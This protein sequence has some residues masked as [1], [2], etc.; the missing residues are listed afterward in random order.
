MIQVRKLWATPFFTGTITRETN[1]AARD[2]ILAMQATA[3]NNIVNNWTTPD[4]LHTRVEFE[5]LC[6]EIR[7]F[8]NES[9][10]W[11]TVA[12]DDIII[13]CMWANVAPLGCVHLEHVH[14]NAQYSGVVYLT[15]PQGAAGTFFRDPRAAAT[16]FSPDY[17]NPSHEIIGSDFIIMPEAGKICMWP[18]WL[19]HGVGHNQPD[20]TVKRIVVSYN[21]MLRG[22]ST[23]P[24]AYLDTRNL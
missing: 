16:M 6:A 23:K 3:D 19:A 20:I 13:N 11:L 7:T 21:I 22:L 9:L 4:D 12:R 18:A 17:H 24:T 5:P 14:S 1:D 15:A 8:V 2:H 10:D